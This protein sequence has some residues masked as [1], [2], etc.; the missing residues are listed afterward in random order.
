MQE[1]LV[2][3][4]V[5]I[6]QNRKDGS[7]LKETAG[8]PAMFMEKIFRELPDCKLTIVAPYG[9]DFEP[10]RS[11]VS[12]YPTMAQGIT[13]MRYENIVTE[14]GR[15]QQCFYWEDAKPVPIDEQMVDYIKSAQIVCLAPLAPTIPASYVRQ[16]KSLMN[17]ESKLLMLPQG[18][19]R[20][21]QEDHSVHVRDFREAPDMLPHTD[22]II[23][24]D[25]DHPDM[26]STAL[27]WSRRY[28]SSVVVT[29]AEEGATVVQNGKITPVP[30]QPVKPIDIVNSVGA[31]DILSAGVMYM[32]SRKHTLVEAVQFGNALARQ[33][34]FMKPDAIHI[35]FEALV[36]GTV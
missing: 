28:G 16:I 9:A 29:Q 31:G 19:F 24:S 8:S 17:S 36:L 26:L 15:T 20:T 21:I 32:L 25:E 23:V 13:T 33:C 7:A 1:V 18:Y 2:V 22:I 3:G 10:Y 30:T 5:C 35:D 4:H 14:H 6:D 27:T 11:S 12:L 34:L